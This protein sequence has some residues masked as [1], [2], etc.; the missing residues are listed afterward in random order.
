MLTKQTIFILNILKLINLIIIITKSCKEINRKT[1]TT[2]L[3]V[4]CSDNIY[5]EKN[6]FQ[7]II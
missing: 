6:K 1:T 5:K 2:Y 7:Q 4:C 3:F